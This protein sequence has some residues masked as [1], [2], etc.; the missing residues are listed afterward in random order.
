VLGETL[1]LLGAAVG[2]IVSLCL[3]G[4]LVTKF[5]LLPWLRANLVDPV[6]NTESQ[7]TVNGHASDEPTVLDRLDDVKAAQAD[8]SRAMRQFGVMFDH[9]MEWADREIQNVWDALDAQQFHWW[10]RVRRSPKQEEK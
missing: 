1:G 8:Q 7:V 2:L 3:L 9:H 6:K 10:D 5:V 4:G